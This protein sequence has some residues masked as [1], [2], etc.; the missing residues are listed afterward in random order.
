MGNSLAFRI[1][2]AY[3]PINGISDVPTKQSGWFCTL[4]T[5][6]VD[7]RGWC[8]TQSTH[9]TQCTH[10]MHTH[11]NR[12]THVSNEHARTRCHICQQCDATESYLIAAA[13]H[14]IG[15]HNIGRCHWCESFGHRTSNSPLGQSQFQ[16][17]RFVLEIYKLLP[18]YTRC[19]SYIHIS[20]TCQ[21]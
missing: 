17:C 6:E 16:K 13:E 14:N 7:P 2:S 21:R 19:L 18:R 5:C 11:T 10:I 3:K 4:Y 1:L 20:L 9:T 12:H 15:M 8:T